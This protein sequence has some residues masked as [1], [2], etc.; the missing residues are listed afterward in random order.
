MKSQ[1]VALSTADSNITLFDLPTFID[2]MEEI[3]DD[4]ED[5][6]ENGSNEIDDTSN[7]GHHDNDDAFINEASL[8]LNNPECILQIEQCIKLGETQGLSLPGR[9]WKPKEG[10]NLE[11]PPTTVKDVYSAILGSRFHARHCIIAPVN[12]CHKKAFLLL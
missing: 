7:A 5:N 8:N 1:Q 3:E 2:A 9:E 10:V 12:H 11:R 4:D 6:E